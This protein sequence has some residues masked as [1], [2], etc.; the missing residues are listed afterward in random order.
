MTNFSTVVQKWKPSIGAISGLLAISV[1]WGCAPLPPMPFALLDRGQVFHGSLSPS[2]R[3][4]EADIR[5]KHFQGYYLLATGTAYFE[6]GISRRPYAGDMRASFVSNSAR[7][8]M[9]AEDGERL[10]CDFIVEDSSA[11]GECNSSIGPSYQLI[12]HVQ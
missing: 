7:A 9:V 1:L 11:I 12:T 6:R 10:S 2:D 5:G 3:R 8:T 4:V